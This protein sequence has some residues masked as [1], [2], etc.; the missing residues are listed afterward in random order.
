MEK[1]VA[2]PDLKGRYGPVSD[3]EASQG[4]HFMVSLVDSR[5]KGFQFGSD[6]LPQRTPALLKAL[7]GSEQ[8]NPKTPPGGCEAEAS[9]QLWGSPAGQDL[10]GEDQIAQQIKADSFA[11]SQSDS[12]VVTAFAQWSACMKSAGYSYKTPNDAQ[13]D[14]RWSEKSASAEEIS[15][16][17][18]DVACKKA[19]GLPG[20]WLAVEN[21]IER[22]AI[23][24]N[25]EALTNGRAAIGSAVKHA[26]Q[27]VGH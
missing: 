18:K 23:D 6:Q 19:T 20:T 22:K 24:N 16:A 4:Y 15:T 10:K 11:Q 26:A 14:A 12:R 25:I 7:T 8:P 3:E 5:N 17:R 21:E 27:V 13:N 2:M 1:I 9:T